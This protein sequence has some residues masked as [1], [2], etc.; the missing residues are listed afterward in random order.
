V[1]PL[2]KGARE[3]GGF[4]KVWFHLHIIEEGYTLSDKICSSE[5]LIIRTKNNGGW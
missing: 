4:V 5:R 1:A 2:D 3:S